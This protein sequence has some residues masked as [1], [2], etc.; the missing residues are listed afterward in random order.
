MIACGTLRMDLD[1]KVKNLEDFSHTFEIIATDELGFLLEDSFIEN[2]FFTKDMWDTK[3]EGT[4]F[5][6]KLS[7][8]FKGDE[9][10]NLLDGNFEGEPLNSFKLTS[11]NTTD[12]ILYRASYE[13]SELS[14]SSGLDNSDEDNIFDQDL[15]DSMMRFN[16]T[17]EMPGEIVSSNADSID[18]TT[19][20]FTLNTTDI[21]QTTEIWVESIV[22][23]KSNFFS[24]NSVE[25]N[26][27]SPKKKELASSSENLLQAT[28][29]TLSTPTV[30]KPTPTNIPEEA[31]STV[32][33]AVVATP[34]SPPTT[35][36][37]SSSI[38]TLTEKYTSSICETDSEPGFYIKDNKSEVREREQKIIGSLSG[39]ELEEF[40]AI[41]TNR[42]FGIGHY[43]SNFMMS[44]EFSPIQYINDNSFG[45]VIRISESG[46][47]DEVFIHYDKEYND[48][49][50]AHLVT[51]EETFSNGSHDL[52][53][54]LNQFILP[55]GIMNYGQDQW[56]HFQVIVIGNSASFYINTQHVYSTDLNPIDFENSYATFPASGKLIKEESV[57]MRIKSPNL[58]CMN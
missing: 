34:K 49:L 7:H 15:I 18:G 25:T 19:A 50:L 57:T 56:N 42:T 13:L 44:A 32:V 48:Y 33:P 14:D 36:P 21:N 30:I 28:P 4:T 16:W 31:K 26:L 39:D 24:C 40:T 10:R 9:A 38:K 27:E 43:L 22:K 47:M 52:D 20:N 53:K 3:M 54:A 46:N 58:E 12:G 37:S 1:S 55:E 5:S 51:N 17:V 2:D 41:S 29:S 8:H 35:L 6:A 45:Y 23:S 11:E